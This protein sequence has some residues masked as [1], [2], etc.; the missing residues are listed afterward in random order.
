MAKNSV[1]NPPA[2]PNS[3]PETDTPELQRVEFSKQITPL[4][5][6]GVAVG[7]VLTLFG[8]GAHLILGSDPAKYNLVLCSGIAIILAAFGGQ[9]TLKV[10][11]AIFA[12]AAGIAA[13]LFYLLSNF[14]GAPP[15]GYV[16]GRISNLPVGKYQVHLQFHTYA[17]GAQSSEAKQFEF[18]A[19]EKNITDVREATLDIWKT[20][21]GQDGEESSFAIPVACFKPWIGVDQLI[22]WHY[23]D[24][25]NQIVEAGGKNRVIA[26]LGSA[27]TDSCSETGQSNHA[28]FLPTTGFAKSPQ[29]RWA[30]LDLVGQAEAQALA[31]Q[32]QPAPPV[33]NDIDQALTLLNSNTYDIRRNARDVLA[34]IT[35]AD[36]RRVID[37]AQAHKSDPQVTLGVSLG[38]TQMLRRD[39]SLGSQ[40]QLTPDDINLLLDFATSTDRTLRIYAGEFL[41][42]L[43]NPDV[44]KAALA[45]A[46]QLSSDKAM[47]DARFNLL[48]VA[49]D[50]YAKLQPDD[51]KNLA[52]TFSTIQTT[53]SKDPGNYLKTQSILDSLTKK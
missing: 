4:I 41:Y 44:A 8:A 25:N 51:K 15:T 46:A 19:F 38:L 24:K 34:R 10:K 27:K 1:A 16:Q 39:K 45:R 43:G 23:D 20:K 32:A 31:T 17:L 9:A 6:L 36:V 33:A 18:I 52:P 30:N 47:D 35:P 11:A 53:L 29:T 14:A 50:G 40:V 42:D 13:G 7:L 37:Y 48:F 2:A 22:D 28:N 26:E 21:D 5:W 3:K 12:G 49:Q